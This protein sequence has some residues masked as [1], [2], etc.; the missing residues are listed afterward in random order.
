MR[1]DALI[2]DQPEKT[3]LNAE[4]KKTIYAA[5]K[6]LFYA[7][8][9]SKTSVREIAKVSGSS[10]SLI[11]YYFG[12]KE[13][14]AREIAYSEIDVVWGIIDNQ[15]SG[16][17]L[18][19]GVKLFVYDRLMWYHIF[20]N[21]GFAEFY[22]ELL[23]ETFLVD[24][25]SSLY[26]EMCN[27]TIDAYGLQLTEKQKTLYN[28]AMNGASRNFLIQ[29]KKGLEMSY[30]EISN[31]LICDYFFNIGLTDTQIA[32]IIKKGLSVLKSVK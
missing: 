3:T 6:K 18:E 5:A 13:G 32:E 26:M 24:T 10:P 19:P 11:M 1:F 27:E 14:L 28:L 17:S 25:Q 2:Q 29:R 8:G 23:M 22:S 20:E 31:I 9:Y 16:F 30:D 7:N 4:T 21:H 15:L 12:S